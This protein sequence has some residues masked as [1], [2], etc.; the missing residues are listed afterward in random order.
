MQQKS[1]ERACLIPNEN[2]YLIDNDVKS[3]EVFSEKKI[4]NYVVTEQ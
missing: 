1:K 3:A 2:N 4:A